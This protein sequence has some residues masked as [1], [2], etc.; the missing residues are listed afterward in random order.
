MSRED[1]DPMRLNQIFNESFKKIETLVKP[2]NQDGGYVYTSPVTSSVYGG[3]SPGGVYEPSL[4]ATAA[5]PAYSAPEYFSFTTSTTAP[6][7]ADSRGDWYGT[8]TAG[9]YG[10]PSAEAAFSSTGKPEPTYTGLTSAYDWNT[11]NLFPADPM[12]GATENLQ[13]VTNVGYQACPPQATLSLQTIPPPPPP[14]LGVQQPLELNDALDVM[15][16]H[17]DISKNGLDAVSPVG[18][19]QN[20]GKRKLDDYAGPGNLEDLQPS[21]SNTGKTKSKSKRS[22]VKS[23]V[24]EAQSA[25][26]AE[27]ASMDPE[28]K[29]KKDKD[30]RYANNQ[31]ERV[32][33]RDINDAL[34]ELGRIC[35]THKQADKPMT[36]LAI[37]NSAVDV[38]MALENQVRDRNLNPGVAC[39]KR[40]TTGSS[41]TDGMSPSPSM[42][43]TSSSS[44][45]YS[46]PA[47][48][49]ASAGS[50][51]TPQSQDYNFLGPTDTTN[52]LL[53]T[54]N[55]PYS[56]AN[57]S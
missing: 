51:S 18:L 14:L 8:P 23:D 53:P 55:V 46:V 35:H 1:Q 38:I 26:D 13:P 7:V 43:G 52:H 49:A 30:R 47:T 22:R 24:S 44:S 27:D 48:A 31:R 54:D 40:R 36:K 6:A 42:P 37:L 5:P 3:P 45:G 17:A 33:I 4:S 25:E 56:D 20:F 34:K 32:R 28:E 29:D 39:L 57:I 41:S 9:E 2:E 21:S 19:A 10:V 50:S 12:Y 15:K 11:G 16:T